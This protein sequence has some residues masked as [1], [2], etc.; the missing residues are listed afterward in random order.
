MTVLE[1]GEVESQKMY[2]NSELMKKARSRTR[3][4][5]EIIITDDYFR[6]DEL[7]IKLDELAGGFSAL[8]LELL[9]LPLTAEEH[10]ILNMNDKV[11]S[12]I[13][14]KQRTAVQLAMSDD[15]KKHRKAED[16]LYNVVMPGQ[17][18]LIDA[19]SKMVTIEQAKIVKLSEQS[20]LTAE[21]VHD[22]NLY[23]IS[24]IIIV[25]ALL[26]IVVV[27]T[28]RKTQLELA[29]SYTDLEIK[30]QNRT[31]ELSK[32]NKALKNSSEHDELTGIYNRRKFNSF[33][34]EE[35]AQTNRSGGYFSL[36]MIDI[37]Y[38]KLYNDNYGHQ[39]GDECLS[40]VASIILKSLPR[41]CDFVAR[42]GG[43]EFVLILPSTDIE[44]AVKVCDSIRN[45]LNAEKI[46]HEY[47]KISAYI[48]LSQGVTSYHAADSLDK[49]KIINNADELLYQAKAN[50]RNR[51]EWI[52]ENS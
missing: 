10:N 26:S 24:F 12:R 49:E 30:V 22:R 51:V 34:Y 41:S 7:N 13:L 8:R 48:T 3:I 21:S 15:P 38:F 32:L 31:K 28:I 27:L 46:L 23:I 29:H 9:S 2:I 4:T 18:E 47:S 45:N 6:K 25:V 50:G 44:G 11:V 42:Y 33:L 36:V 20:K 17:Q 16:I 43:E 1:A 37:D 39:K 52:I 40:H 35:V 14:P 19:F 5:S